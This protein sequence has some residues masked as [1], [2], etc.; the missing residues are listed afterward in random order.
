MIDHR[1]WFYLVTLISLIL[2][3]GGTVALVILAL[4][5]KPAR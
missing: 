2:V 3:W 5:Q 4:L 1:T